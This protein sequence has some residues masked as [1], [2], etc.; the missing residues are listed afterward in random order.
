VEPATVDLTQ[1]PSGQ[2]AIDLEFAVVE[3]N[4]KGKLLDKSLIR[5]SGKLTPAQREHISAKSLSARQTIAL[6]KGA[7]TLVLGVR[8][9][10]SGRFGNLQIALP[11]R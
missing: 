4:A 7:T 1:D 10:N 2:F 11:S 8:D 3:Y 5:L 9:Q 6:K